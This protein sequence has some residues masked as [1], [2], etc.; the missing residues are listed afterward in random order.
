[1]GSQ[2]VSESFDERHFGAN[3]KQIRIKFGSRESAARDA[4]SRNAV[5]AGRNDYGRNVT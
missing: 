2:L 4:V 1:L 3:D 5:I